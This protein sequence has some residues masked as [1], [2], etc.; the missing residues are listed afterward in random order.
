MTSI[1]V[2]QSD[3]KYLR[4]WRSSTLSTA[5]VRFFSGS[6]GTSENYSLALEFGW[7][8]LEYQEIGEGAR[9][10]ML[11][12]YLDVMASFNQCNGN[13][14]LWWAT[15]FSSRNRINSPVLPS[16][17][18][19]TRSL[20]AIDDLKAGESLVLLNL[21]WPAVEAL[22]VLASREGYSFQVFSNLLARPKALAKARIFSWWVFWVGVLYSIVSIRK[23]R[24]AFGVKW[25]LDADT[26][27]YLIKSFTYLRNFKDQHYQDP[28]FGGLSEHLRSKLPNTKVL[29]VSVGFQ[30]REDCYRNMR[31]L[32]CESVHPIEI[33]LNYSDVMKRLVQWLWR[34]SIRQ[35]GMKGEIAWMER[36][37][38]TL[39]SEIIRFGGF[40]IDFFQ[41]LHYDAA[42]RLGE[43][44]RIK[45]CLMT[46]EG[47]PWERFFMAGLRASSPE[48]PIIGC[49]HTVIPLSAAD[50]FLHP[51]ETG[52]VPLPDKIV[53]TGAFTK[54]ILDKYGAY[55]QER[56]FA[57]CALR[58]ESLHE[59][60]LHSRNRSGRDG[61]EGFKMLVAF[62]G[63]DEEVPLLNY[64]LEQAGKIPEVT[65]RTRT[66]PT[67]PL[68]QLH[69]LSVW[70][71]KILPANL[72]D[73]DLPR[74]IDDLELCD[75][76][77]YW[78][79][80][81]SLEALMV[82]K[83]IIQF[84][85]GDFLNYDP[86]FAFDDF[87]WKVRNGTSLQNALREIFEMPDE[88][89][90]DRQ[91]RGRRYIEDYLHPVTPD[92]LSLFLPSVDC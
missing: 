14:L 66:H 19:F 85:R 28:F 25:K 44:Y 68:N 6:S 74:V 27:I 20:N 71:N 63:S 72:V 87:K 45:T 69:R 81:V 90:A 79:T 16:L 76:V 34:L 41:A 35:F 53:T 43:I 59:V 8:P 23:A 29:T 82:G 33:Y 13:D 36:D 4:K 5:P 12:D 92:N 62:G 75:A 89:Y 64:T 80:T 49:Q 61:M 7:V 52:L 17:Q 42:R 86:L 15:H 21:S 26:P 73:S 32:D 9:D 88:H 30:D 40:R 50:M 24:R 70:K 60:T 37:A 31:E 57:G 91:Q 83:P 67:F 51:K 58:F 55:P 38:T 65:F 2:F 1:F 18:D 48:S 56:T 78:G 77:L 11:T 46:Y 54:K 3:E 47:R 39:F 84:D 22:R 10:R